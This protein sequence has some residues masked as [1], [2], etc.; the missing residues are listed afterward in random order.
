MNY[1]IKTQRSNL[2]NILSSESISPYSFYLSRD[3]GYHR[4]DRQAGELYDKQLRIDTKIYDDE[5]DVIYIEL[6]GDDEQIR[7]IKLAKNR[8]YFYISKTIYLYP[9]NCRIL[10]K[11]VED[12]RNSV[13][14]CKS[15]LMNKMWGYYPTGIVQKEDISAMFKTMN[16]PAEVNNNKQ[17]EVESDNE[18]NRLKG[19]LYMYYWGTLKSLSPNL[20][21]L[22]QAEID[23]YGITTALAGM[24]SPSS[25][26]Y[27]EVDRLKK[28]F[29]VNDPNR[30]VLKALWNEKVL[31]G[32]DTDADAQLF[33][34][35][36]GKFGV[37]KTVMD[38]FAAEQGIPVSPRLDVANMAGMNWRKFAMQIDEYTQLI[39]KK[40]E[41]D[42][43]IADNGHIE[44]HNGH[45]EIA[46]VADRLYEDVLNGVIKG[47]GWLSVERLSSKKLEV[48][49]ELTYYAKDFYEKCGLLWEGG[50][51]QLYLN[52]LRLNIANS[53]PFDPNQAPN[54]GLRA[55]AIYVL[56]GDIADEMI[57]YM[58]VSA[59]ED[60]S[61]VYGLWGANQGYA[62]IPKTIM[63]TASLSQHKISECYMA[64][65]NSLMGMHASYELNPD[66]FV[67]VLDTQIIANP[68][69]PVRHVTDY[70]EYAMKRLRAP[71][72]NLS[73]A[74]LIAISG[75]LERNGGKIDEKGFKQ[76]AE[77]NGIGKKKLEKIKDVLLPITTDQE[78]EDMLFKE[79]PVFQMDIPLTPAEV[80][81]VIDD[82]IPGNVTVRNQ[83]EKD[84]TWYML[85]NRDVKEKLIPGLCQFLR[86]N[87]ESIWKKL[88]VRKLYEDVD[89]LLIEKKLKDAFL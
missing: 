82:C 34:Q 40:A 6:N 86:N 85:E 26:I 81:R 64:M 1:Y 59:V 51:E 17:K 83:V 43:Q 48:A 12:A 45:I 19:F 3:Y 7:D 78:K 13:F 38:N 11:S 35:L 44:V 20:A 71:A 9:W 30:T 74:Q 89:V 61:L 25:E 70:V 10:F 79:D 47:K 27:S 22:L 68:I 5:E 57:K 21:R 67:K 58:R 41:S 75:I 2:D 62:G 73:T 54:K 69:I 84:V 28:A 46:H 55:L 87:K 80:M 77:I 39:I 49:N 50:A 60:Y 18:K 16:R 14:L 37:Q 72:Y 33:E 31:G 52:D 4:F 8:S 65:Y 53:S 24:R 66:C 56:K 88:W 15:S 29:N 32:F 42:N 76:I 63:Q 23:L 36:L